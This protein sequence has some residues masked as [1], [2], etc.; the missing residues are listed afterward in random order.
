MRATQ[1]LSR[2]RTENVETPV[3]KVPAGQALVQP[4]SELPAGINYPTCSSLKRDKVN[5]KKN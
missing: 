1:I 3:P 4:F 5:N 2:G